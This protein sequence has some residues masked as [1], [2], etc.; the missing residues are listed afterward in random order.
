MKTTEDILKEKIQQEYGFEVTLA[1]FYSEFGYITKHDI[2]MASMKEY[3]EQALDLAAEKAET[4]YSYKE[5]IKDTIIVVDK[6]S[7]LKL[8]EQ[9]K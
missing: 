2:V 4:T 5:S 7:I 6:E 3:A 8:K 1:D 9:L